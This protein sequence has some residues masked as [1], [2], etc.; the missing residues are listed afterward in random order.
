MEIQELIHAVNNTGFPVVVC[1]A[2]FWLVVH[3]L[4]SHSKILGELKE[5]VAA[6]TKVINDLLERE[7]K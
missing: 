2:L 1:G 6:N 7:K 4:N 3:L 5:V